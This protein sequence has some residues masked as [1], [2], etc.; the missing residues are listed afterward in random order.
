MKKVEIFL[1]TKNRAT[2]DSAFGISYNDL[3]EKTSFFE[4]NLVL[5]I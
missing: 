3:L 2:T 1:Q 4:G 5:V